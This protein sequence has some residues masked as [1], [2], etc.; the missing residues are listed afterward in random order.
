MMELGE[1]THVVTQDAIRLVQRMKRDWIHFGRRPAGIC[2]ACLLLAARMHGFRRTQKEIIHIVK[3]CNMTLRNRLNEF[4]D[5]ASAA[6]TIDQFRVT[7]LSTEANPPSF[8]RARHKVATTAS[9]AAAQQTDAEIMQEMNDALQS[10]EIQQ[11]LRSWTDLPVSENPEEWS[12]I[13]DTELDLFLLD[14]EEIANKTAC[15]ESMN[16]EWMD[17][18][19][20]KR[21]QREHAESTQPAKKPRKPSGRRNIIR[22]STPA[23]ATKEVISQKA[24][25]FSKKI[26]YAALDQLFQKSALQQQSAVKVADS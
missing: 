25:V 14:P 22:A 4:A 24:P 15:W 5:T 8:R 13:D 23:E 18:Q 17:L 7:D 26:N 16:Q 20:L 12:D 19:Q 10:V 6:L 1:K 11:A 2:G 9:T 3:I 21:Q